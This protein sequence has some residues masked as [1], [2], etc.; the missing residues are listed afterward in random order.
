MAQQIEADAMLARAIDEQEKAR[1]TQAGKEASSQIKEEREC[2]TR[3]EQERLL[4]V[5]K[6]RENFELRSNDRD[7]S[8]KPR[9][10]EQQFSETAPAPLPR[11]IKSQEKQNANNVILSTQYDDYVNQ[12]NAN[13]RTDQGKG[14][15]KGNPERQANLRQGARS[16]IVTCFSCATS[17]HVGVPCSK[18]NHY[19]LFRERNPD[20][21]YPHERIQY[22]ATNEHADV[23]DRA[24][25]PIFPQEEIP[26]EINRQKARRTV[27]YPT[28]V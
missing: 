21:I 23:Q 11:D 12:A 9:L 3:Q 16:P 1:V 24:T 10:P 26:N 5:I 18:L 20:I 7:K 25:S 17:G 27:R 19:P 6:D 28:V 15:R 2:R 13:A 14:D 4:R 22:L 8:S